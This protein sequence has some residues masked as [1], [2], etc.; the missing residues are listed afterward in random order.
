MTISRQQLQLINRRQLRYPLDVAEKDYHLALAL[1]LLAGS[2]LHDALVFK[3]GTALHHCYLP[4]NRFSEDLDFTAVMPG[5]TSNAVKEALTA[6]GLFEVRKEFESPAT[7]K[8][9]RLW[10]LG[11]LDQAGAIKV[12]IDRMQN[13][14]LPAQPLPYRNV[15]NL[16]VTVPVMDIREICAE[17][18]RAASQ[19]ARYRDF[20]DLYLILTSFTLDID[21]IYGLMQR[22]EVRAE[23]SPALIQA[24]W[25]LAIGGKA[26]DLRSIYC[27]TEVENDAIEALLGQLSFP[28][29]LPQSA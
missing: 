20:Y 2:S 14:V 18:I 3:G 23:I 10:Y 1:Q 27:A 22:K 24:N 21:E 25:Q 16:D 11:I 15:W 19:R 7:I 13:V 17:K 5:L 28:P 8:F 6:E 4:Q 12:E 9:E 29:I 26:R